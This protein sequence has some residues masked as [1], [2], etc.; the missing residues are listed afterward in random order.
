MTRIALTTHGRRRLQERLG[1]GCDPQ[2]IA[3]RC[4]RKGEEPPEEWLC[5]P[6]TDQFR[7]LKYGDRVLVFGYGRY[8]DTVLVTVLGPYGDGRTWKAPDRSWKE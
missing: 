7:F 5:P 8:G 2:K 4:W 3:E 1:K 6:S